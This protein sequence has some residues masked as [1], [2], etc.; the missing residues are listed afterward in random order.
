MAEKAATDP[1]TETQQTILDASL[2]HIAF[3]GWSMRALNRGAEDAGL[4]PEDV[5]R[6][7]P[8]GAIDA[9]E[10]FTKRAD[11]T[12]L[13]TLQNEYALPEMKIRERIATAVMV[14]LRQHA[15]NREAVRRGLAV[16]SM[17]WNAGRGMR[18]LYRTVDAMWHAAGDQSTDFNFYTKRILL[19]KVYMSTMYV[20]LDDHSDN[21][22]ETEAFLHRRISDV[23]QIEKLK[24]KARDLTNWAP[25]EQFK[26]KAAPT[27]QG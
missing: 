23:M 25:F 15:E 11:D 21:L 7:F 20:W 27:S 12:M 19:S 1:I 13:E 22:E 17:P 16:Y 4:S 18:S 14:R 26:A 8:D 3:D 24:A 6:V 2:P 9:L 5:R 10:F